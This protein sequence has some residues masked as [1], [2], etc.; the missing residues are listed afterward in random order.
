MKPNNIKARIVNF[1]IVSKDD[2][3]MT[4]KYPKMT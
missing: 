1:F 4:C 2:T 3:Y